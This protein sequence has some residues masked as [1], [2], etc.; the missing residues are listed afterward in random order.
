MRASSGR[1]DFPALLSRLRL[2]LIDEAHS[3]DCDRG[4]TIEAIMSRYTD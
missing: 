3:L 2:V 4:P 1:V